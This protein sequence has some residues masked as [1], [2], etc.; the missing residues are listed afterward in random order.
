MER[1]RALGGAGCVRCRGAGEPRGLSRLADAWDRLQRR[2]DQRRRR[3]AAAGRAGT[4]AV[5]RAWLLAMAR[6][7]EQHRERQRRPDEREPGAAAGC[8][9]LARAWRERR[10]AAAN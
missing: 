1:P 6:A 2:S 3:L 8:R 9:A 10:S 7:S 4:L 5:E